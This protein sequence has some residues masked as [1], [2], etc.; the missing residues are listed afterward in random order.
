REATM[1]A[2]KKA[3]LKIRN[4]INEPTAAALYYAYKTGSDLDGIY[5]VFD[6]GGG[7]FDVSIIQARGK[8]VE[9]LSSDGV[10]RLGGDDFDKA[11][12]EIVKNKYQTLTGKEP[13]TEISLSVAEKI[14][15]HLSLKEGTK[16][17]IDGVTIEITK[18]EFES[19]IS[20]QLAQIE[21]LCE[22]AMDDAK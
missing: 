10:S 21:M 14:K 18:E 17:S 22:N 9:I 1:L 13:E 12:R 8:N 5:A 3:G 19:Q 16:Q 6:L 11:I 20:S 15:K 4:I 2:A 7:T